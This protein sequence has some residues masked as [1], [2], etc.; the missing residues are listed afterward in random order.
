LVSDGIGLIG[1]ETGKYC[2]SLPVTK[3]AG[4]WN[5]RVVCTAGLPTACGQKQ[6]HGAGSFLE[7]L[8]VARLVNKLLAFCATPRILIL[9]IVLCLVNP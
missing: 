9:A 8:I 4:C 5:V 7:K 1:K 2:L 6:P 3:L